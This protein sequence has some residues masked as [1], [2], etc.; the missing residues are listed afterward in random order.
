MA[1]ST[2]IG[3]IHLNLQFRTPHNSRSAATYSNGKHSNILQ[4]DEYLN[5]F[6]NSNTEHELAKI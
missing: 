2:I 4:G 3:V 1:N 5:R 6:Y